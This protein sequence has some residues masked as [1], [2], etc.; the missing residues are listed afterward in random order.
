MANSGDVDLYCTAPDRHDQVT[1]FVLGWT[2]EK[3]S[4]F[5]EEGV[6]G[7]A[8]IEPNGNEHIEV[9]AWDELPPWPESARVAI[10]K[11]TTP[12]T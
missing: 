1:A 6:E 11:A 2:V 10:A 4:L 12:T 5:D 7:W 9:G 8:W 3:R